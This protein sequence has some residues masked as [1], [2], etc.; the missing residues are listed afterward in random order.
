[1]N[2]FQRG[3]GFLLSP[4][5]KK[6]HLDVSLLVLKVKLQ[7]K[8]QLDVQSEEILGNAHVKTRSSLGPFNIKKKV[9][10]IQ[11]LKFLLHFRTQRARLDRKRVAHITNSYK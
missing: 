4:S 7:F 9:L 8:R 1:M 3:W 6:S 2:L 5:Q 10:L 11:K